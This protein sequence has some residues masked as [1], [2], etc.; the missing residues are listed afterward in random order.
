[1]EEGKTDELSELSK[2]KEEW[3]LKAS[4]S[5]FSSRLA[6]E[7]H[8]AVRNGRTDGCAGR[9]K[10]IQ[11]VVIH[12]LQRGVSTSVRAVSSSVYNSVPVFFTSCHHHPAPMGFIHFDCFNHYCFS[13]WNLQGKVQKVK[14]A[15]VY[16]KN[17]F[18]PNKK[19]IN[20]D[21]TLGRKIQSA[22]SCICFLPT[23]WCY[24]LDIFI[25][26]FWIYQLTSSI[27]WLYT[28]WWRKVIG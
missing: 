26:W 22:L 3:N 12:L 17:V 28:K 8:M 1:M 25:Q 15:R 24:S 9:R 6:R 16:L 27:H 2:T 7:E 18:L 14:V 13:V 10:H 5:L 21:K 11:R 23:K 4:L 19:S 20:Q